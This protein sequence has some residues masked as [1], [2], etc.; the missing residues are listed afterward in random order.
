[1][2]SYRGAKWLMNEVLE[3]LPIN[4]SAS[5]WHL[6]TAMK[7]PAFS[8]AGD[9]VLYK[10]VPRG[11]KDFV[12]AAGCLHMPPGAWHIGLR[13]RLE[14]AIELERISTAYVTQHT[15]LVLRAR[16]SP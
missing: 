1:M 13:E 8:A 9:L 3:P 7:Q 6:S 10:V 2:L 12:D 16:F 14:D 11:E 5:R 15:H 4:C